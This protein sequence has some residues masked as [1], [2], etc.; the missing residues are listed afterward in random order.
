MAHDESTV[1]LGLAW[2]S[3]KGQIEIVA[4]SGQGVTLRA[5]R[6]GNGV[7]GEGLDTVQARLLAQLEE[8]AAYR[9]YYRHADPKRLVEM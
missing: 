1:R 6:A 7:L 2:M 8:T 9:A 5:L 3:E 4:E